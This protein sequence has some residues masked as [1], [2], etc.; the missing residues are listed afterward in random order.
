LIL[1]NAHLAVVERRKI[2]EYLLN[3]THPDN[4]G[5][6]SFF[7]AL[8]FDVER[9]ELLAEALRALAANPPGCA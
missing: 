5:K 9:W 6:A 4:G 2:T 3:P 7:A 1:P 8:G